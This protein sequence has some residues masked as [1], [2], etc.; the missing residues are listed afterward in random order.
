MLDI[1]LPCYNSER[2]MLEKSLVSI[3]QQETEYLFT[4]YVVDDGSDKQIF[5]PELVHEMK[6]INVQH[7]LIPHYGLPTALNLGH[8]FSNAKYIC[9][10]SDDNY[11]E[12]DFVQTMVSTA[13]E[14]EYDFVRSLEKHIDREGHFLG[15]TDPRSGNSALPVAGLYDGYLGASHIYTR[16]LFNRTK[17]YDPEMAGIEDLDFWYQIASLNPPPRIPRIGH[18][19]RPLY[20]YREGASTFSEAQVQEARRKF[21]AKWGLK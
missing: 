2:W 9:W 19:D 10:T 5:T 14:G 15:I 4:T 11:Y 6:K 16:E 1:I 18:V 21:C 20:T 3:V 13:E 8:Y 12:P 17:G 7:W